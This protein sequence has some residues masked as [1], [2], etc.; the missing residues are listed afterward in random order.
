MQ[1]W[2]R[3][4]IAARASLAVN[5][6]DAV[7]RAIHASCL[8][9]SGRGDDAQSEIRKALETDPMNPVVLYQAAIIGV[10]RGNPEGAVSWLERAVRAGYPP[11]EAERDPVLAPLRELSSYR[12]LIDRQK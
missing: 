6:T 5:A 3:G 7:A 8:A 10:L 9:K 1:A 2:E 11:A 12:R 4:I